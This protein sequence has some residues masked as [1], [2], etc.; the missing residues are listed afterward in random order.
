MYYGNKNKFLKNQEF[1]LSLS[2]FLKYILFINIVQI[3]YYQYIVQIR[4]SLYIVQTL[5]C[6]FTRNIMKIYIIDNI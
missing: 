2:S 4:E 1:L 5:N 3:R 6:T